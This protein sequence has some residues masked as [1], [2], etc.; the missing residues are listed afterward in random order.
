MKNYTFN[1]EIQ[2]LL[3]QFVAAFN[4]VIIKRYNKEKNVIPPLSG[5]KVNYVYGPKQRVFNSLQTPAPGGLTVPAIAVSIGGIS[6]DNNRVFNKNDGFAVPYNITATPADFIKKIPQP[7]PL[8]INVNMTMITRYQSDMDQLISNFAPYC[9]PYIV[10]SWKVP[11][12]DGTLSPYEIRTEVLWSGNINLSYPNDAGPNTPFRIVADT[13]FVIKGW[14]FKKID[15]T[16]KKIYVINSDYNA[17]NNTQENLLTDIDDYSTE[18]FTISARPQPKR[19]TPYKAIAFQSP[20]SGNAINVNVFGKSFFDVTNVYVSASNFAMF[21]NITYF[22]PFSAIGSLSAKYPAFY[23]IVI[24]TFT[25]F[26][27][28]FLTFEL[29]ELP[30]TTGFLDIIVENEAGYGKLTV[31]SKLPFISS[32]SGATNLQFPYISGFQVGTIADPTWYLPDDLG[33]ILSELQNYI[34]T[35]WI[36]FLKYDDV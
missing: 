23:G 12:L 9:D 11:T 7:V 27:E 1:W 26:N 2:T 19:I 29:P 33:Y 16:Y 20:L 10:I 21:D 24:P 31:D 13:S 5:I 6:R 30:N 32:W 22:N 18:W 17:V 34:I 36:G 4:D 28:N 35:D 15:E 25:L 3:E 14:I 8:N